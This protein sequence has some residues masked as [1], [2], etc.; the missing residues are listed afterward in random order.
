MTSKRRTRDPWSRTIVKLPER[1]LP[2]AILHLAAPLLDALG[3]AP[4]LDDARRAIGV[5]IDV[6]NAS[7]PASPL[8]EFPNTKPL[9]ALRKKMCGKRAAPG[10]ADAFEQLSTRWRRDHWLD[11]RLVR[12]WSFDVTEDGRR[13]LRCE[14]ELPEGVEV[15][16]PPPLEKRIAIGGKLLDEV[17]IRQS[18]NMYLSFPVERHRGVVGADGSVTIETT[19]PTTVQLFAEGLLTPIGG[20]PVE[21]MVGGKKLAPCVLAQVLSGGFGSTTAVLVFRPASATTSG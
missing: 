1:T 17:S 16:V 10:L 20:A 14:A 7:L 19:L 9:D 11:P 8:W 4:A 13:T 6:W 12:A 21:L 18:A 5:A 15:E 2:D 3:P